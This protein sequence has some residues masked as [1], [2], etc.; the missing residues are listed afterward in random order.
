ML[1]GRC[2][3]Y[4]IINGGAQTALSNQQYPV[5]TRSG[6]TSR[7]GKRLFSGKGESAEQRVYLPFKFHQPVPVTRNSVARRGLLASEGMS[8]KKS[9][10]LGYGRADLSSR[11]VEDNFSA[12]AAAA[13]NSSP[14]VP[15]TAP[16]KNM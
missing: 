5:L 9:S 10:L 11:G 2:R 8:A 14:N 13:P 6:S 3:E 16:N 15:R 1:N 7:A 4:D 12:A